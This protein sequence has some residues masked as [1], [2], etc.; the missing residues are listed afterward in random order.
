M[1]GEYLEINGSCYIVD[2]ERIMEFVS[3][4]KNNE[5]EVETSITQV[6]GDKDRWSLKYEENEDDGGFFGLKRTNNDPDDNF[7]LIS[8][9]MTET[10][11]NVSEV[12]NTF[13]YDLV[14]NFL[15][16]LMTPYYDREGG[17]MEI[18]DGS[19]MSF[20]MK[21][22]FNTLLANGILV[23]INTEDQD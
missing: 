10:K 20:G 21:L 19:D 11:S 12:F 5:K 7:G 6:F 15:S 9:E 8:K 23:E 18:N 3:T 2:M 4:T 17:F 13:R 14:K 1:N 16:A 22:A